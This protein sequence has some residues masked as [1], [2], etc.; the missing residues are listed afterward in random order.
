MLNFK[1][2][3]YKDWPTPRRNSVNT[4]SPTIPV[5]ST[6]AS[7]M[8]NEDSILPLLARRGLEKEEKCAICLTE[9]E[10]VDEILMGS[11][12]HGFHS[13]CLLVSLHSFFFTFLLL[14]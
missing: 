1:T 14:E 11:C 7:V 6:S 2:F 4:S 3:N 10:E 5:A 12:A 9:Y 8:M 13:E